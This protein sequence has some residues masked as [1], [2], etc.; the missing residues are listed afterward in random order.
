MF[1]ASFWALSLV[2]YGRT[3][4]LVLLNHISNKKVQKYHFQKR[5]NFR[6]GSNWQIFQF[7]IFWFF[8][9]NSLENHPNWKCRECFEN[10]RKFAAR[11]A[12][13]FPKLMEKC[14]RF[15]IPRLATLKIQWSEIELIWATPEIKPFF[16]MRFFNFYVAYMVQ[17]Y[18]NESAPI[19][20]Y[21]KSPK[22]RRKHLNIPYLQALTLGRIIKMTL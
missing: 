8:V 11:W 10:F 15:F 22:T 14:L 5:L 12:Q 20:Y 4:I 16:N 19:F 13:K 9:N 2:K 17:K 1:S 3:F 7:L 18:Q 6:G 21:G